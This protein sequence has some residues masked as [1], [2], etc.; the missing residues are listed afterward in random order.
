MAAIAPWC[1]KQRSAPAAVVPVHFPGARLCRPL[2]AACA[3]LGFPNSGRHLGDAS[4]MWN[5]FFVGCA[6]HE[7]CEQSQEEMTYD[8]HAD[9]VS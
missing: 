6:T 9:G 2:P 3:Q 5:V 8:E 4:R 7:A 1:R